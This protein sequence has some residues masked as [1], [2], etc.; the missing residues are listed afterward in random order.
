MM[1]LSNAQEWYFLIVCTILG[2]LAL[3]VWDQRGK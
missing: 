2:L 1:T 3:V